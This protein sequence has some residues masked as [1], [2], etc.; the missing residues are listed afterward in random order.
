M[1]TRKPPANSTL[2]WQPF[3][4]PAKPYAYTAAALKKNWPRLHRGDRE[5]LP[6]ADAVLEQCSEL[7][8]I[9]ATISSVSC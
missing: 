4:H 8:P 9:P 1:T 6:K 7:K 3:P 5:P 2:A